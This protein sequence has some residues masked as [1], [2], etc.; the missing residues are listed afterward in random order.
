[1]SPPSGSQEAYVATGEQ[2]CQLHD[3]IEPRYR[4]V[5]LLAAFTSGALRSAA[6]GS[7]TSTS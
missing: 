3:A 1:M 2:V 7:L 6:F 4:A 5:L